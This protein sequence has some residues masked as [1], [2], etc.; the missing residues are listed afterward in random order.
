MSSGHIYLVLAFILNGAANVTLKFGAGKGASLGD[1]IITFLKTN[2]YLF[3]GAIFFGGNLLFYYHALSHLPLSVSYSIMIAASFI[4]VN[5]F[6][7]LYFKE[8]IGFFGGI[9]YVFILVGILLVV[10]TSRV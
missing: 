4:I 3:L 6:S 7:L 2:P 10:L 9:G 5:L 1:G 8:N